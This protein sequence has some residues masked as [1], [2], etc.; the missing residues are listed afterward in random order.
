MGFLY[1][2]PTPKQ[3]A[4]RE[5]IERFGLSS[6]LPG[7]V[8]SRGCTSGPSGSP[9]VV[10][11]HRGDETKHGYY[12]AEQEWVQVDGSEAWVGWTK[13]K[14]PGPDE[15]ARDRQTPLGELVELDDGRKWRCP[16]AQR[17][18]VLDSGRMVP[19]CALSQKLVRRNGEWVVGSIREED[20]RLWQVACETLDSI[21]SGDHS[22]SIQLDQAIVA[23]AA[24]YRV[25]PTEASVMGLFE[26][27][28][29]SVWNVLKLL[30]DWK[31]WEQVLSGES[32]AAG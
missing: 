22:L 29:R 19:S 2:V 30:V 28:G 6:V 7:G 25:G 26:S 23:V 16:I 15:L 12:P 31:G 9:G 1:F 20:T 8:D 18:R 5:T 14:L 10:L 27:N 13:G 24:N 32:Q 3:F 4:D 11:R 17:P 21:T